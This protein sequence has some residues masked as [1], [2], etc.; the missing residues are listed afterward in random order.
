MGLGIDDH[1]FARRRSWPPSAARRRLDGQ[2]A[3][4]HQH[5]F[6]FFH[7]GECLVE[8][9]FVEVFTVKDDIGFDE[10]AAAAARHFSGEHQRR[11]FGITELLPAFQAVVPGGAAVQFVNVA[12]ARL[13]V[14]QVDILSV[15]AA[16]Q[17]GLFKPGKG[18]VDG[19]RMELF[20][21]YRNSA[22]Q[23]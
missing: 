5:E 3:A 21:R 16:Q 10:A 13:L 12:A 15:Y 20:Q 17:A 9:G 18:A 11:D 23:P 7:I 19:R 22:A 2:A 14:E 8:Q 6:G 4:E 1:D